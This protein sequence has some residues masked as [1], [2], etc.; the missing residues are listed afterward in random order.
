[1]TTAGPVR[2]T[3]LTTT[4]AGLALAALLAMLFGLHAGAA[5]AACTNEAFRT[6]SGA[7]LPDCRAYEQ[8]SPVDKN[9][10]GVAGVRGFL[11]TAP[12]G[13]AITFFNSAGNG[14]PSENGGNQTYGTYQASKKG[15]SW[16]TQRLMAPD[17]LGTS[18][19]SSWL[20]STPD[21]R[22]SLVE[23]ESPAFP[24]PEFGRGLYLF[25]NATA[26]ITEIVPREA[27]QVEKPY[28]F[29]GASTDGTRFF[30]ETKARLTPDAVGSVDHLYMWSRS[31][32]EVSLVGLLPATEGGEEPE[33]GSFGGAYEWFEEPETES[34]GALQGLGVEA[35]HAIS[36]TGDQI[37]FTAGETGQL[38]LRRGL[39]GSSPETVHVS[40]PAPGAPAEPRR[41]AAFQ[42]A[43]PSGTFAFFLS[44]QKLTEDA[45]TGPANEGKDLYRWNAESGQLVDIAP[46]TT[47]AA[48]AHVRGVV[49]VAADGR[50]GYFVAEGGFG[51]AGAVPNEQNLY[52]F[53][54]AEDKF[55]ITFIATLAPRGGIGPDIDQRNYSPKLYAGRPTQG[56]KDDERMKDARVLS[57][58]SEMLFSSIEPLT[59]YENIAG[60]N[61]RGIS[62][63]GAAGSEGRCGE[64]FL[65]SASAE[66]VICISC[67]PSGEAPLGVAQLN[68]ARF[69]A[70]LVPNDFPNVYLPRNLSANGDHIFFESPDPLVSRDTNA[71]GGCP[72]ANEENQP[73]TTGDCVDVYEWEAAGA[74]GG[75]CKTVEVNGGCL[76]LLS[77]GQ[78]SSGSYFLDASE[79]GSEAF[80][81]TTTRLVPSDRDS[82]YDAYDVS[83]GGGLAPQFLVG[84][85][86]C[87]GEAC[88]GPANPAPAAASAS[89]SQVE[90]PGNIKPKKKHHKQKHK[91]KHVKKR[92]R[93]HGRSGNTSGKGG[94]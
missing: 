19:S 25:E 58:G 24:S 48:G 35:L 60:K 29:D 2:S 71:A 69:N 17:S 33:G 81:S 21:L 5:L 76:Y 43:T 46:D 3:A 18:P 7:F 45:T 31:T 56:D 77:T 36:S 61:S 32:G 70:A 30:F 8:A 85:P 53:A 38:Y 37:Y 52:R 50:S 28:A 92:A 51:L 74:P 93:H 26:E 44:S 68:S 88:L 39:T 40:A 90:G 49:G 63:C 34:G 57:D 11:R 72:R 55:T 23:V 80:I 83:S 9:G 13:S 79:D 47:D 64:I 16:L 89:S 86:A 6:G 20:G 41:P 42:E 10:A 27:N 15:E 82:L 67:N 12:K 62:L 22:Y 66:S 59:G 87:E 14:F 94:N 73:G 4:K 54:E 65:Y 84:A 75:S 78:S 91:K 1:M